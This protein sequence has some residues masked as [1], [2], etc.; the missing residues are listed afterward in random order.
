[1]PRLELMNPYSVTDLSDLKF[2]VA[3]TAA[4]PGVR[5][6]ITEGVVE[7][8]YGPITNEYVQR[9]FSKLPNGTEGILVVGPANRNPETLALETLKATAF[10][11]GE[12]KDLRFYVYDN[13]L[14][15]G[16][17][18]TRYLEVKARSRINPNVVVIPYMIANN[19]FELETREQSFL[20]QGYQGILIRDLNAPY[21]F[22]QTGREDGFLIRR[23]DGRLQNSSTANP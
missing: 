8:H 9:L 22:G 19:L 1:M 10:S 15:E 5:A 21:K 17:F 4:F 20:M 2:P 16:G 13:R 11:T 6:D 18:M 23:T 14:V 12:N 3:V 7:S